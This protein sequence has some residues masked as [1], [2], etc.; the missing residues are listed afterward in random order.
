MIAPT[1]MPWSLQQ[2]LIVSFGE[3][4]LFIGTNLKSSEEKLN[5]NNLVGDIQ[6][7]KGKITGVIYYLPCD[8]LPVK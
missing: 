1:C 2:K 8:S 6:L 5:E 4:I 7:P 3:R